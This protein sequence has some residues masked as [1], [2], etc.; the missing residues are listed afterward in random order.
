[1]VKQKEPTEFIEEKKNRKGGRKPIAK[2]PDY[3]ESLKIRNRE[4]Q[5][6]FQKRYRDHELS[7]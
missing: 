7:D 4:R 3:L 1:M 5:R 2:T 6:D